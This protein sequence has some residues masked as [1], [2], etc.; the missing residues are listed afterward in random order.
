MKDIGIDYRTWLREANLIGGAW[1]GADGGGTLDV[2]N[3]ATAELIGTIPNSGQAE[4]HVP[5]PR[6]PRPFPVL[7]HD[8]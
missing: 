5:F 3:P 4:A 2:T 1:V 6:Q 7:P 8:H